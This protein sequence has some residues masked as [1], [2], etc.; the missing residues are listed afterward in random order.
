ME[1]TDD[2]LISEY[3]SGVQESL[4]LLIE[5]YTKPIFS[6]AYRMT[7]KRSDA[8]DI[9]QETFMKIWQTLPRYK[10]TNT[11]R[12]W[13][14]TI[15]RNTALDRLR[16]KKMLVFSDFDDAAGKNV[17]VETLS[18]PNTLPETLIAKAEQTGMLN[19]SLLSLSEKD[20]EILILHYE[21]DMTFETIGKILHSPLNTI[22]SRHRRALQKLREYLEKEP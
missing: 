4:V 3:R 20:R 8:E 12:S 10:L 13:I 21:H 14:F 22:K 2:E 9:T 17:L 5:R 7:G 15:A 19:K 18:D 16:K 11:F 1:K 6:F